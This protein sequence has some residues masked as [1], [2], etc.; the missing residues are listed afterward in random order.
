MTFLDGGNSIGTGTLD[1]NGVATLATSTLATGNHTITASYSGNIDY[2]T[3]TGSL[4]NN[5]QIV[6]A[7]GKTGNDDDH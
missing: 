6:G 2:N 5:P 7:G 4:A 1:V 3:S